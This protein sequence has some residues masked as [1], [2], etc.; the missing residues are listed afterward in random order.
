M[1]QPHSIAGNPQRMRLSPSQI[2]CCCLV[3][4]Y[5]RGR[6]GLVKVV[7]QDWSLAS[8]VRSWYSRQSSHC[9]MNATSCSSSLQRKN[10]PFLS[11]VSARAWLLLLPGNFIQSSIQSSTRSSTQSDLLLDRAATGRDDSKYAA[12]DIL[13]VG[14]ALRMAVPRR[15]DCTEPSWMY[16]VLASDLVG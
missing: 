8:P 3:S 10:S 7:A 5:S 14:A 9:A 11:R 12:R 4:L 6:S 2:T 15:C 13:D 1:I 16:F